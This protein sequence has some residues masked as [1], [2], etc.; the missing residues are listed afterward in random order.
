MRFELQMILKEG[1]QTDLDV[2]Y[3]MI[4]II[5]VFFASGFL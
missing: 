4:Q 1:G 3:V 2:G 5:P